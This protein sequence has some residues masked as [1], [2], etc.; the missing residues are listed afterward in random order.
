MHMDTCGALL[1]TETWNGR[2][3]HKVLQEPMQKGMELRQ[4]QQYAKL[5]RRKRSTTVE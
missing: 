1:V 5:K 3:C 4:R 2:G